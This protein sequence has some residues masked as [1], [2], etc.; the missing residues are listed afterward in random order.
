MLKKLALAISSR[1]SLFTYLFGACLV[2]YGV[3]WIYPPAGVI[4][5]G[6]FLIALVVETGGRS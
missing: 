1:V 4:T 6:L 5:G 2:T 3:T